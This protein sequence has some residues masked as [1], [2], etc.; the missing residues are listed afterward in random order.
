VDSKEGCETYL[1]TLL[2]TIDRLRSDYP[3]R[4]IALSLS[5]G[6]KGMSALTLF[7]AQQVGIER[8]YHT[9]ITDIALEEHIE[10]ET[11]IDALDCLPTN[12][13]QSQ[14]LFLEAYDREKF[15]LFKIPIIP[16]ASPNI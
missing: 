12:E 7:A 2:S 15:E 14:R 9:L 8:L 13:A 16:F 11:S 5:G 10:E 4:D 6:R 3:D 1:G